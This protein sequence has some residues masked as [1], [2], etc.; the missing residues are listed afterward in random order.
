VSIRLERV[1]FGLA[2]AVLLPAAL[3]HAAFPKHSLTP[4]PATL[5]GRVLIA[6]PSM[7]DPRFARTVILLVRHGKDGAFGITINRPA[8]EH[9]FAS[10]LGPLGDKDLARAGSVRVFAGGPVD[11]Q[12]GFV[13]HS[14][15]WEHADTVVITAEMA[16]TASADILRA[17]A[18]GKGPKKTLVA[19]GYAGWGAGQ[20][21]AELARKD[22]LVASADAALVFDTPRDRVWDEAMA[23]R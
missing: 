6:S 7:G 5:T 3:V 8:G 11:Q 23:R 21:E 13:L 1:L 14:T 12:T 9:S 10:L 4:E 16:A 19:F 2:A 22:W 20:L 15:D 17:M 18:H